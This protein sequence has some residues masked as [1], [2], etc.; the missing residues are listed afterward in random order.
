MPTRDVRVMLASMKLPVPTSKACLVLAA[1]KR[2]VDASFTR[3][4]GAPTL[5]PFRSLQRYAIPLR[6]AAACAGSLSLAPW[7]S[8]IAAA[9]SNWAAFAAV[10]VMTHLLISNP[11][12]YTSL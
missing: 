1:M 4:H 5:R 11:G 7:C 8:R 12:V 10:T 3:R 9:R 6:R 2:C